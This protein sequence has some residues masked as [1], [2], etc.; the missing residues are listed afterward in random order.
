MSR[1]YIRFLEGVR[2][3]AREGC[4]VPASWSE[5]ATLWWEDVLHVTMPVK[6]ERGGEQRSALNYAITVIYGV[7]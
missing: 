5:S 1:I 6:R 2:A 3:A 4:S 7:H